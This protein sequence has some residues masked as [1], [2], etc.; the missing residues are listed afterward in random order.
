MLHYQVCDTLLVELILLNTA[1][2]G[3]PWCIEDANLGKMLRIYITFINTSTF[4]YTIL[5]CEFVDVGRVGLALVVR[6]TLLVAVVKGVEV[7]VID[8]ESLP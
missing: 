7:V 5:D 2:I 3:Q 8:V 1:S 4:H 6:T